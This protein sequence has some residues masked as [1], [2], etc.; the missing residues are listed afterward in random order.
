MEIWYFDGGIFASLKDVPTR[1]IM[2]AVGQ[3][4]R[5]LFRTVCC[6][7]YQGKVAT[8]DQT[9]KP[10]VRNYQITWLTKAVHPMGLVVSPVYSAT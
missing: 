2:L 7:F 1:N 4:G 9:F 8:L 10:L 3:L 6:L 5:R